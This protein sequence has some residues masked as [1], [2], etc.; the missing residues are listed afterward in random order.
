MVKFPPDL[1]IS[2]DSLKLRLLK[3]PLLFLAS[4]DHSSNP[5]D[6]CLF[7]P[8]NLGLSHC[9]NYLKKKTYDPHWVGC[10]PEATALGTHV[11]DIAIVL[12][13]FISAWNFAV[14]ELWPQNLH[15]RRA[16]CR[17]FDSLPNGPTNSHR[18]QITSARLASQGSFRQLHFNRPLKENDVEQFV[19]GKYLDDKLLMQSASYRLFGGRAI[20][21]P[22][23]FIDRQEINFSLRYCFLVFM[24]KFQE[25]VTS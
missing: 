18:R 5:I 6:L 15:A 23:W 21:S 14:H 24:W 9:V 8:S 3:W 22:G 19:L 12:S 25:I 4:Y 2:Q 17:Q 1:G 13:M 16:N 20:Y 7:T 10:W 11:E